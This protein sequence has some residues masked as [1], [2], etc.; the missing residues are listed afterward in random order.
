MRGLCP[1]GATRLS[2]LRIR[3]CTSALIRL[4]PLYMIHST[5]NYHCT[6]LTL[7]IA[8]S[9]PFQGPLSARRSLFHHFT[10]RSACFVSCL[11]TL[12]DCGKNERVPRSCVFSSCCRSRSDSCKQLQS[13]PRHRQTT[14][15]HH[16]PLFTSRGV[17]RPCS[18]I[19]PVRLN[20]LCPG[21][22]ADGMQRYGASRYTGCS[23]S[24]SPSSASLQSTPSPSSSDS[25]INEDD[26]PS[27]LAY[28]PSSSLYKASSPFWLARSS[29]CPLWKASPQ[30]HLS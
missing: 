12:L 23:S 17:L 26:C 25:G 28:L 13:M 22:R 18:T 9:V 20:L 6:A 24:I 7:H 30:A 19:P 4:Q 5:F 10:G 11:S 21:P 14:S 2:L 29:V 16:G 15:R 1:D 27:L 8:F 3:P